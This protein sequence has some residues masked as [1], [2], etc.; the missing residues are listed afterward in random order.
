[1]TS[2]IAAA[3][4][5]RMHPQKRNNPAFIIAS[6]TMSQRCRAGQDAGFCRKMLPD[7][8]FAGVIMVS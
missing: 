5:G 6:A 1:M 3:T 7:W 4:K 8:G 2:A